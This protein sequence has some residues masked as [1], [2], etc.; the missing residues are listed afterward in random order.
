MQLRVIHGAGLFVVV[1]GYLDDEAGLKEPD[2]A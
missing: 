2:L 1:S